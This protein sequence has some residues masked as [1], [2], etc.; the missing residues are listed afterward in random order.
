MGQ[1]ADGTPTGAPCG[2]LQ[3][4]AD[5]C[6]CQ[7]RA[8]GLPTPERLQSGACWLVG[9]TRCPQGEAIVVGLDHDAG[10]L[11]PSVSGWSHDVQRLSHGVSNPVLPLPWACTTALCALVD[12]AVSALSKHTTRGVPGVMPHGTID[13]PRLE[14]G[15]LLPRSRRTSR[16]DTGACRTLNNTG[17][18]RGGMA[19]Q[20]HAAMGRS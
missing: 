16:I 10:H 11:M 12:V 1:Q 18:G 3:R 9:L 17:P 5:V 15:A 6:P 2:P 4:R 13:V 14:R 19:Y 20:C 7:H 8:C